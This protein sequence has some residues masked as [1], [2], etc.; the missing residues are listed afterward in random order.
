M[1][2]EPCIQEYPAEA[3]VIR[4]ATLRDCTLIAQD[5]RPADVEE[6]EAQAAL[7]LEALQDSR[8]V[9]E[10]CW[11]VA[12]QGEPVL[13]MGVGVQGSKFGI[14]WMLGTPRIKEIRRLFL[15]ES[16]SIFQRLCAG[17]ETVGNM[18]YSGNREHLRW[19]RWMKFEI[20]PAAPYNEQNKNLFHLVT[21]HVRIH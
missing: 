4:E 1:G 12:V 11:T 17:Y 3:V 21:R 10:R 16:E 19:L 2:S 7:P 5:M 6:L 13:M 18:V 20:A 15:K 9:S 14:I 8:K